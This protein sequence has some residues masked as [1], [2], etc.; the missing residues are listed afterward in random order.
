MVV[1][2][3]TQELD[4]MA[5]ILYQADFQGNQFYLPEVSP[6]SKKVSEN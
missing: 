6:Y 5:V 2:L 3:G 4:F 1:S